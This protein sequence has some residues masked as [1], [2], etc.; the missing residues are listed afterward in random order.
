MKR[1]PTPDAGVVHATTTRRPTEG[2]YA[3]VTDRKA[4]GVTY[5]PPGL[6]EYLAEK[7][8]E[9]LVD[10]KT[11]ELIRVLDPA[12]GD[13]ALVV[14]LVRVL[15]RV[16]AARIS[17]VGYETNP[18]AAE[19][20]RREIAAACPGVDLEVR[21]R[22]F[23]GDADDD[24][25]DLAIANPPYVRTQ[26][27]GAVDT[28]ALAARFGLEG[29]LDLYQ[30]FA[31]ALVDRL[32]VGGSLALITSN[33]FLTTKGAAA[34]RESLRANLAI[35]RVWDLGDT[36]L[37]DATVLP[38]ML[39]ASRRTRSQAPLPDARFTSVYERK[40][41]S[42]AE[43]ALFPS[44]LD[45][46]SDVAIGPRTFRISQGRLRI[47]DGSVW[48]LSSDDLEAWLRTVRDRTWKP[49]G[50]IG[51]I[52]VGV[53][54]TSDRV[55][56]REDWSDFGTEAPEL[57][58]P[59]LTHHAARRYH[60]DPPTRQILYP[61]LDDSGRRRVAELDA[62]PVTAA[63]LE[64]HRRVLEARP[65]LRAAGR[66]WYELWVPHEPALWARTK[67]VFRDI[68]ETP[69]FF[70]DESGSV[71]NGDCYWM[72]AD[73]PADTDVLFL[74]LAVTNSTFIEA[75]YDHR[76]NNKLFGGRRRFMTQ[77]VAEFPLPDPSDELSKAIIALARRRHRTT[78][79]RAAER[80]EREID[81]LVW[82]AFG[83]P[84]GRAITEAL[85][86][87]TSPRSPRSA[88]A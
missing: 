60:A 77:Y 35:A 2:R 87:R 63:Y 4:N 16:S 69:T 51:K 19:T 9:L 72:I 10:A 44:A 75:F 45:R 58:R 48:R 71:V 34:F 70:L 64:A 22:D 61:H 76:F 17:V 82:T 81:A 53:K 59:L 5:T 78:D 62:Y 15:A 79:P 66:R 29:R 67:L 74:A 65:Y 36:K 46:T 7:L 84:D 28:A 73:D 3:G 24:R 40:G 20:A 14:A 18:S 52:R 6:A 30:A 11:R 13:G 47:D 42:G 12:I 33:R 68:A 88:G 49:L 38:A 55:F 39:V 23:L 27:L 54:S 86:E 8:V 85:D 57:L 32:D 26:L 43:D 37:F 25:F 21:V 41:A 31:L 83:L 50:A 1:R 80:L 56:I